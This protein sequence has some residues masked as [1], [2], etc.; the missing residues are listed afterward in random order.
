MED[1]GS[2]RRS[3]ALLSTIALFTALYFARDLFLPITAAMLIALTLSPV[4]R[5]FGRFG[6]PAPLSAFILISSTGFILVSA[7]YLLSGPISDFVAQ[8]PQM[9]VELRR[10]L[11]GVLEAMRFIQE[12]S[13]NVED[14]SGSGNPKVAI[15]QPGMLVFAAGTTASVLSLLGVAL[16][17][18]FF[19][20]ASGDLFYVKLVES[21]PT[22]S[23]KRRAVGIMRAIERQM[24]HYLLTVTLINAVLGFC[25]GVAMYWVGMPNPM[26]WGLLGFVLNFVPFVGAIVGVFAVAAVGLLTFDSALA[27]LLPA[28]VYMS[29]T[30]FE[31]Q[32]VTPSIIGRRMEL[33]TVS[34]LLALILWSWL[35][36]V[37]GALM[38]VPLLVLIKVVAD[39]T[40]GLQ[41][42]GSFLGSHRRVKTVA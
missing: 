38:A 16:V 15:E 32:F 28:A 6:L 41:M 19:L 20:L 4:V 11:A 35:W 14:L 37:P 2:I 18:A 39:N 30:T 3:L 10:K 9:G 33:N 17:L 12:A 27:G 40:K 26:L 29:I 7:A 42:L 25:L 23:D 36:S 5:A 22:F 21:V 8:A 24:S 1:L 31:G 34:V 13:K